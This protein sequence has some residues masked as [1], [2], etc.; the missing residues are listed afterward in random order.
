MTNELSDLAHNV[1]MLE[2][3]VQELELNARITQLK[4]EQLIDEE[5]V[6]CCK[7]VDVAARLQKELDE[8][9]RNKN[10]F[11]V[12][13][14]ERDEEIDMLKYVISARDLTIKSLTSMCQS[15]GTE[16]NRLASTI[17]GLE[18]KIKSVRNGWLLSCDDVQALEAELSARKGDS[19]VLLKVVDTI[20]CWESTPI[21]GLAAVTE[22]KDIIDDYL[23]APEPDEP[24]CSF[25]GSKN[26]SVLAGGDWFCDM[27]CVHGQADVNK[28]IHD[29]DESPEIT[30]TFAWLELP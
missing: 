17:E 15:S 2:L 26:P 1:R 27:R 12:T 9:R 5:C 29:I 10:K 14:H 13:I 16:R 24:V 30:V 25:C 22:I 6:G 7:V 23:D 21:G 8:C 4:A 11:E 19:E 18:A 20:R 3:E 28:H